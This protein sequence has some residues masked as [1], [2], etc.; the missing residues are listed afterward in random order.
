VNKYLKTILKKTVRKSKFNLHVMLYHTLW[1]Y[2]TT[3]NTSTSFSLFELV[4]GMES[5]LP[6][7]CEIPSLILF[8]E[9]LPNTIDIKEHLVHLEHIDEKNRDVTISI[10]E[11]K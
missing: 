5:T 8:V 7:E 11:N 10:E 9:L 2:Q 6:I 1:A 3:V 4:H